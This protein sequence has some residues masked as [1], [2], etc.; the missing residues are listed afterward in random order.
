MKNQIPK[1][2]INQSATETGDEK[3]LVEMYRAA[4]VITKALFIGA[5]PD[6]LCEEIILEYVADRQKMVPSSNSSTIAF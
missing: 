1:Q 6:H 3:L 4:L 2:N 5:F